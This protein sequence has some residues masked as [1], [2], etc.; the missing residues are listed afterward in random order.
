MATEKSVETID[1]VTS[2][3]R[4]GGGDTC[5]TNYCIA[6][7]APHSIPVSVSP[8]GGCCQNLIQEVNTPIEISMKN[9]KVIFLQG[10][11][12][13]KTDNN[14]GVRNAIVVATTWINGVKKRFVG[15]TRTDGR[16]NI[17]VPAP[18]TSA[19]TYSIKAFHCPGCVGET[20]EEVKCTND[21]N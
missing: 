4:H 10:R 14:V 13:C 2:E 1:T 18:A 9:I 5:S 20:S 17:C 16:Y 3:A 8:M 19:Q 11:V 6:Q 15:I 12:E 21:G 7:L